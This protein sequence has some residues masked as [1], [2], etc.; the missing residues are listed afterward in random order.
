MHTEVAIS[1]SSPV[2]AKETPLA[3]VG[4]R[5]LSPHVAAQRLGV[6]KRTILG[7]IRAGKLSAVRF[8]ARVFMIAE[9]EL[10][11]F[12]ACHNLRNSS[13]LAQLR[14]K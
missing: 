8:N 3:Q 9:T 14:S 10:I 2:R 1:G 7:C 13:Q 4:V 11:E 12:A 5:W 6:S